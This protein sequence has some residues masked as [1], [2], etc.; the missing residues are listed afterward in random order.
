MQVQGCLQFPTEGPCGTKEAVVRT[1][2]A[3]QTEKLC[4]AKGPRTT[5]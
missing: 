5:T 4:V 2:H 3:A 1:S